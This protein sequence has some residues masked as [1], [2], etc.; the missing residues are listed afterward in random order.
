LQ[1]LY[2]SGCNVHQ[3]LACRVLRQVTELRLRFDNTDHDFKNAR[4]SLTPIL[5][6]VALAMPQLVSLDI[7][8]NELRQACL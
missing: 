5:E 4:R 2:I 3:L 8:H 1:Q 6:F 7:S